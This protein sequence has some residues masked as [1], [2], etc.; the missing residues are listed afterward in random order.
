MR[1]R[2]QPSSFDDVPL[3]DR[4][5]FRHV[6]L[7]CDRGCGTEVD[8]D[9]RADTA[10]EAYEG[11]RRFAVSEHGWQVTET[12]DVCPDCA[13]RRRPSFVA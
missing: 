5:P 11:L 8:A 6:A 10:E 12:E 1:D 9:I 3:E 7:F 13:G 4:F 2:D